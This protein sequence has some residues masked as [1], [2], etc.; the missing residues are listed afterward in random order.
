LGNPEQNVDW[1]SVVFNPADVTVPTF[2][3]QGWRDF[4][5]PAEQATALFEATNGIP[6]FKL[7]VG[8]IG[9]PPASSDINDPEA[10]Y[11][12]SQALRWFDQWLK[13]TD[14]GI[15][16]EPRVTLAPELTADWSTNAL[17]QADTFPLP[18]TTTNTLFINLL[19]L[20]DASPSPLKPRK[21]TPTSRGFRTLSSILKK[22][23]VGNSSLISQVLAINDILN[24][25]AA[26]VLDPG[27]F[28]KTDKDARRMSFSS[29]P[30]PADLQ[31]VGS[32]VVEL[33]VS[34]KKP[35]AYYFVQ[36][37]EKVVNLD[38]KL[39]TRGAFKD[40]TV[41]SKSPHLIQFSPFAVN[42]RFS[43]GSQIKLLI[44]SRDYPFFLPNISQ[45]T[46]RIYRDA[47]HPS[48]LLLPV[49]P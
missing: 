32:P 19:G 1:R 33:Y 47:S 46:V 37:E 15:L 10:L 30:L 9:H 22:I 21:L 41:D 23:G 39:V 4:L 6:F 24:S 2:V 27:M 18:G 3:I 31:I 36:I 28:T 45:P 40:H 14:T 29:D 20:T 13:G 38:A 11:M 48:A 8:G 42:H 5:F 49:A 34:A 17:V 12:R 43:A 7:Y 16:D 25:G 44:S 35:N 26:D